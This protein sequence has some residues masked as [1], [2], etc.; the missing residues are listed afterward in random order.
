M[1]IILFSVL[2]LSE[3]IHHVSVSVLELGVFVRI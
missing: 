2:N 3:M 1:L